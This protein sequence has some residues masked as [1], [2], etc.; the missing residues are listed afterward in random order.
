MKIFLKILT[1][2]IILLTI[3]TAIYYGLRFR[4]THFT[5]EYLN[6]SYVVTLPNKVWFEIDGGAVTL[7][8]ERIFENDSTDLLKSGIDFGLQ[9]PTYKAKTENKTATRTQEATRVGDTIEISQT[10]EFYDENKKQYTTYIFFSQY[11]DFEENT[12]VH[13]GCRVEITSEKGEVQT[14]EEI[15]TAMIQYLIEGEKS[16]DDV[17]TFDISCYEK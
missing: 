9:Y 15:A 6:R 12:Y 2:I 8:D 16:I 4:N 10:I 1:A 17:I 13:E 7:D 11:G 3:P 5:L 14:N